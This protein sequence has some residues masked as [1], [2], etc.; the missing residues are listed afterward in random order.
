MRPSSNKQRTQFS[1]NASMHEHVKK[2]E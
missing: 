2:S 1:R